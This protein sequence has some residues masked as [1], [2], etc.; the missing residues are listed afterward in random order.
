VFVAPP[1]R[2]VQRARLLGRDPD[3]DLAALERRL[4]QAEAE[5]RAARDFD[6]VVVNDDLNRAVDEVAAILAARRTGS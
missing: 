1:S 3:A 6:A 4:D 5:E 2:E